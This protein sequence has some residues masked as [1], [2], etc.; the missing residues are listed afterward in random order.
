MSTATHLEHQ[1]YDASMQSA[2]LFF[3]QRHQAEHLGN[4]QLLFCRAVQHLT[5]SLEVPLHRAEKLVTRAYGEL[6]CSNNR[7]QLDVDASSTTVA[8]VTDP[9]SGLI[10][11]VPVNLIYERIINATDNRRLR[12]V[13]P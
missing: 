11:A 1:E 8:V 4:D 5:A 7:H 6:K 10:W 13:T 12:F 3:L 9:S 2:A